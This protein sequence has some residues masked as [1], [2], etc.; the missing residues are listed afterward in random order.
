V[1]GPA[2]ERY[3]AWRSLV[4][5]ALTDHLQVEPGRAAALAEAGT[6]IVGAGALGLVAGAVLAAVVA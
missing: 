6:L 2:R 3:Q 5:S 4:A 1:E